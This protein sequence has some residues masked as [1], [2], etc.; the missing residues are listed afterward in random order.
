VGEGV[1]R[2][3][4]YRPSLSPSRLN[5]EFCTLFVSRVIE[6]CEITKKTHWKN[7]FLV[8]CATVI[9]VTEYN[10]VLRVRFLH[11]TQVAIQV[12]Y[13]CRLSS[14]ANEIILFFSVIHHLFSKINT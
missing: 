1:R 9:F 10:I 13:L 14:V 11:A 5:I 8:Q 7:F 3:R 12:F 6:L 4:R 2:R